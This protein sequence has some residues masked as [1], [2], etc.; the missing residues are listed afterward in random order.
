MRSYILRRLLQI[1]P[2]VLMISLVVF[3]MMRSIPGDPVVAL[4]G[5]AYTEE[6]AVKVREAYG[7]ESFRYGT[8]L[9]AGRHRLGVTARL[10]V[11]ASAEATPDL[12]QASASLALASP[13]GEL[14]ASGAGS[15]DGGRGGGAA[16]LAWRYFL[17]RVSFGADGSVFS[18]DYANLQLRA[19]APR[20]PVA[21]SILIILT[22][23]QKLPKSIQGV[24]ASSIT[25]LG[26]I[27][28]QLSLVPMFEQITIP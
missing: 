13:L 12:A 3:V 5:D 9:L 28:F 10:T 2:T 7:L 25:M 22:P 15:V 24:P 16:L 20:P 26:S 8:P 1:V 4:R 23:P 21:A 19:D 11:G 14:E 17:R 6:D 18:G 27:A